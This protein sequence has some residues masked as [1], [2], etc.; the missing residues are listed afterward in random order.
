[1][2]AINIIMNTEKDKILFWYEDPNILLNQKYIFEFFPTEKMNYKQQLNAIT[3][4]IILLTVII[5]LITP[6]F[7]VMLVSLITLIM[8]YL[9]Y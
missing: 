7:R 6:S 8:I 4:T 9:M 5:M 2:N 1:M 3:R